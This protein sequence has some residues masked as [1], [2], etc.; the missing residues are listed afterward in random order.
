MVF[1][2]LSLQNTIIDSAF[3]GLLNTVPLSTEVLL[4]F[5][6][7]LPTA[8]NL[9][10]KPPATKRRRT[11]HGEAARTSTQDTKTLL[12]AIKKVTFVLQLVE[13]SNVENHPELLRGLFNTLAE[14]QHFKA[15]VSRNSERQIWHVCVIFESWI[16]SL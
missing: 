3:L 5:I 10:D 14:L 11:S 1:R 16:S 8:A 4:T 6:E 12:A 13:G 9:V 7:Q 15:Q 2:F